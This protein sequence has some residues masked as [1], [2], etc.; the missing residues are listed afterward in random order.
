MPG[1][2]PGALLQTLDP[3]YLN[4]D[5]DADRDDH[6]RAKCDVALRASPGASRDGV[7]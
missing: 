1:C 2:M 3:R 5:A 6:Q 7:P 4:A